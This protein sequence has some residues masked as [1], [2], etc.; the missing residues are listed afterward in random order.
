[1]IWVRFTVEV[2]YR[3][4]VRLR[5]GFD[6]CA[7]HLPGERDYVSFCKKRSGANTIRTSRSPSRSPRARPGCDE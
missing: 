6:S 3:Q 7:A 4:G 2:P 5:F 1:M